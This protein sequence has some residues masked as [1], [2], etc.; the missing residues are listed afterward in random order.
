MDDRAILA[1]LFS[2]V[3]E[4][5]DA[6]LDGLETDDLFL[7]AAPDTNPIGW[8][9]WHLTRIED[10]QVADLLDVPQVWIADETGDWPARF[11][12]E[13]DPANHGYGHSPAEVA[14]VRPDSVPALRDYYGAVAR[15]TQDALRVIGP[16]TLDRVVDPHWDP[17]VTMGVRLVSIADDQLRHCGQA[18]YLR[19]LLKI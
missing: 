14:E 16:T 13:P 8:L 17:P 5:V 12:L 11:G 4:H 1:D 9:V 15:T 7:A 18:A 6:V 19:G 2:R 3:G 10:A